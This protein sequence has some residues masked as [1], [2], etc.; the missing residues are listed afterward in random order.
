MVAGIVVGPVARVEVERLDALLSEFNDEFEEHGNSYLHGIQ[1][2]GEAIEKIGG[3]NLKRTLLVLISSILEWH[4]DTVGDVANEAMRLVIGAGGVV[5]H[6]D[7]A[8]ESAIGAEI[9]KRHPN[10]ENLEE[11]VNNT[12]GGL[13][14]WVHVGAMNYS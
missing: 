14:E 10:L 4:G 5:S 3:G 11:L 7:W 2:A 1:A 12:S 8:V 6:N 9:W 13:L